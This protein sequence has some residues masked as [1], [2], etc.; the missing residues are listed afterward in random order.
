MGIWDRDFGVLGDKEISEQLQHSVQ[1][2]GGRDELVAAVARQGWEGWSVELV[3]RC[4][5]PPADTQQGSDTLLVG[6]HLLVCF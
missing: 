3:K 4:V 1:G 2:L 5:P 6:T